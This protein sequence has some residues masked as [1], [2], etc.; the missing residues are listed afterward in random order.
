MVPLCS[1]DQR[2]SN[3][4]LLR[5]YIPHLLLGGDTAPEEIPHYLSACPNLTDLTIWT[6]ETGPELLPF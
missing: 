6:Q 1:W 4:A 5:M 2:F 3:S